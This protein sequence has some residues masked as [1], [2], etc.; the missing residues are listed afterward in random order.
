MAVGEGEGGGGRARDGT[1]T[2]GAICGPSSALT[3][4]SI[5]QLCVSIHVKPR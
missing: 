1:S 4:V 5:R 2:K 3:N